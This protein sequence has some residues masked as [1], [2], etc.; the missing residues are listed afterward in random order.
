MKRFLL[1]RKIRRAIR[2][3]KPIA[4]RS[5]LFKG[6]E[7]YPIYVSNRPINT[8]DPYYQKKIEELDRILKE[9]PIPDYILKQANRPD[10]SFFPF[11]YRFLRRLGLRR[12]SPARLHHR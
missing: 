6:E 7:I 12:N 9:A 2:T 8:N 10:N 4:T 1:Q 5:S 3:G 11:L